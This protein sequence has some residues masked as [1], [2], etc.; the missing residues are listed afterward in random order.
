ME[1]IRL[2]EMIVEGNLAGCREEELNE[3]QKQ[4]LNLHTE[5]CRK[6][7]Y[8]VE[9]MAEFAAKLK[10]MR[11]GKNYVDGGFESFGE[12]VAKA[13]GIKESMAYRYIKVYEDLP[14]NFLYSNTKLGITKLSV[15]ARLNDEERS[16]LTE[17][18]DVAKVSVDELKK[19]ISERDER[20]KQLE[21][22]SEEEVKKSAKASEKSEREIAS[23]KK[24]L[25]AAE[26]ERDELKG[27]IEKI[28]SLPKE[29][30]KVVDP[31]AALKMEELEKELAERNETI[32]SLNNKIKIASDTK[33]MQFNVRF[34]DLQ[35]LLKELM[36]VLS[37]MDNEI[38]NKCK[39]ALKS[40]IEVYGV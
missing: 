40:V 12:Y 33:L 28:K 14:R 34:N 31:E 21:I 32:N 35:R 39:S 36:F 29:I 24:K 18:V 4:F 10:E 23:A 19:I 25:Q 22:S 20:I 1:R 16:E 38:A 26:K 7:A 17:S 8:I 6:G 13:V 27:E 15:L 9:G 2:E 5:I 30:E 3:K 11:D 37:G